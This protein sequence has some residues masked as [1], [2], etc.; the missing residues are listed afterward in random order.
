[1]DEAE[2]LPLK[3]DGSWDQM[4]VTGSKKVKHVVVPLEW[5]HAWKLVPTER[6]QKTVDVIYFIEDNLFLTITP[7]S[8][9]IRNTATI[10]IEDSTRIVSPAERAKTKRTILAAFLVGYQKILIRNRK[11]TFPQ[12]F[13]KEIE[14]FSKDKLRYSVADSEASEI[15]IKASI[16]WKEFTVNDEIKKMCGD[17]RQMHKDAVS[18]MKRFSGK[19][20]DEIINMDNKV[21]GRCHLMVKLCKTAVQNPPVVRF[22]HIDNFRWLMAYRVIAKSL[23]RCADHAVKMAIDLKELHKNGKN[24]RAP[25]S[26]KVQKMPYKI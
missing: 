16:D 19:K 22:A 2:Q 4:A 12:D 23:E 10:W 21:D 20:A 9:K 6:G 24:P 8:P 11:D 18:L 14:Q 25:I 13:R 15:T 1:M 17:V 3:K 26:V 7:R 5:V